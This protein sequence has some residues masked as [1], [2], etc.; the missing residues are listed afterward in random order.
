MPVPLIRPENWDNGTLHRSVVVLEP[1]NNPTFLWLV[2]RSMA[3][4]FVSGEAEK[5]YN[6][7]FEPY[8][9]KVSPKLKAAW[10]AVSYPE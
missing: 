7:W 9:V 5:I 10:E 4:M 1:K 6:K 2:N 3:R 8:G